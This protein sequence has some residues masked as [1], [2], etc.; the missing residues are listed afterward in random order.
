MKWFVGI[1]TMAA[2]SECYGVVAAFLGDFQPHCLALVLA[3]QECVVV[4]Q[5]WWSLFN[6]GGGGEA[7]WG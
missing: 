5:W 6:C 1:F 7:G 4:M 2:S 3:E